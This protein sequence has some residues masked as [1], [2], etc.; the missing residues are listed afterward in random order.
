MLSGDEDAAGKAKRIAARFA[1][2][3]SFRSHR[4]RVGRQQARDNG[5]RVVIWRTTISFRMWFSRSIMRRCTRS[6]ARR[7]IRSSR[8]TVD[9]PG[10]V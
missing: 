4:R 1:D 3:E 2:Y 5:V 8:I 7:H 10:S 6:L 9:E